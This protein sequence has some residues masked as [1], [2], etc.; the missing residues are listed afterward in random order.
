M[1]TNKK[2]L[3]CGVEKSVKKIVLFWKEL[4]IVVKII[5]LVILALPSRSFRPEIGTFR[6]CGLNRT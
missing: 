5:E 3:N 2:L 4:V 1:K 6:N